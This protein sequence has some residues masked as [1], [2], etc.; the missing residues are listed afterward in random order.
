MNFKDVFILFMDKNSCKKKL[1]FFQGEQPSIKRILKIKSGTWFVKVTYIFAGDPGTDKTI[2]ARC[3]AVEVKFFMNSFIKL[4]RVNL[5]DLAQEFNQLYQYQWS[6]SWRSRVITLLISRYFQRYRE[7]R[8]WC[9]HQGSSIR[10]SDMTQT[11][12]V[13]MDIPVVG[14]FF[15]VLDC[16]VEF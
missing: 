1:T 6:Y 5:P 15:T 12:K 8:R 7:Y 14:A 13:I 16:K 2:A 11:A 3:M 10:L 4:L 9:D